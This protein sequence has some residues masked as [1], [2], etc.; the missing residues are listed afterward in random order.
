MP[1]HTEYYDILSV[2]Y[3]HPFAFV[4]DWTVLLSSKVGRTPGSEDCAL[5]KDPEQRQI[6]L[7]ASRWVGCVAAGSV[8]CDTDHSGP[9]ICNRLQGALPAIS[10]ALKAIV[11]S[12]QQL[13]SAGWSYISASDSR[14]EC[15]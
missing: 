4:F 9:D 11:I 6:P 10:Y 14:E 2:C 12:G 13:F 7:Q 8:S 1:M 5:R 15:L 3:L